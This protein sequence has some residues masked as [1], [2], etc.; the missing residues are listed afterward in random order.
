MK[1][2]AQPPSSIENARKHE[3]DWYE[4]EVQESLLF[5]RK[6]HFLSMFL[7]AMQ[8]LYEMD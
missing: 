5:E 8:S 2:K 3:V 4:H 6:K 7:K 1:Q